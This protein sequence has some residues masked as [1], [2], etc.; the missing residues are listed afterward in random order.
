M[1]I[2]AI[3]LAAGPLAVA[4]AAAPIVKGAVAQEGAV[5]PVPVVDFGLV[6]RRTGTNAVELSWRPIRTTRARYVYRVFRNAT[7]GCSYSGI[8]APV[9]AFS[10]P[11]IADTREPTYEDSSAGGRAVY[12]VALVANW[13]LEPAR[14]NALLLSRPVTVPAR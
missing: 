13:S 3:V 14:S 12:R 8:G 6:A 5:G 7:D 9:C 11:A 2:I 10:S 1:V 4:I